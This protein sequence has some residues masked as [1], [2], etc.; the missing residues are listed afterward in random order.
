MFVYF[1]DGS[2]MEGRLMGADQVGLEFELI[3]YM[4]Q[5]DEG[6]PGQEDMDDELKLVF[7]P[8]NQVRVLYRP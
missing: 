6:L 2:L 1:T 8:W 7:V 3:R 5:P 4:R